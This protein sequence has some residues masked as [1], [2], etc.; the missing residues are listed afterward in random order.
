MTCSTCVWHQM[1][2]HGS[3]IEEKGTA[4]LWHY[5]DADPEFGALQA[6]H[7]PILPKHELGQA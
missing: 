7:V 2:T 1:N 4:M 3:Y 6:S 5:G